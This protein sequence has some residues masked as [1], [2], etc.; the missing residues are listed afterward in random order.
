M[1]DIRICDTCGSA[2]KIASI[3]DPVF[4]DK[5]LTHGNEKRLQQE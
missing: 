4:I 1:L 5:I 3:Q 2:M